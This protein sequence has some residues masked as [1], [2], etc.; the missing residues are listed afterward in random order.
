MCFIW[1]YTKLG[2]ELV[3]QKM[4]EMK[5]NRITHLTYLVMFHLKV[6]VYQNVNLL[7]S[8]GLNPQKHPFSYNNYQTLHMAHKLIPIIWNHNV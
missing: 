5:L 3:S 8:Y 6:I 7:H 2:F 4:S 1:D